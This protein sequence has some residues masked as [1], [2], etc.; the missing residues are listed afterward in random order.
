MIDIGLSGSLLRGVKK[1]TLLG[2]LTDGG[3]F[4]QLGVPLWIVAADLVLQREF[5]FDRGDLG[6]ALDATSAIPTVF[7][8]VSFEDRQLVDGWVV[9]P[10]PADVLRSRG[11]RRGGTTGDPVRP[12]ART[13]CGMTPGRQ[14]PPGPA[15]IPTRPQPGYLP[16][17]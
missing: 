9:N 15:H 13:R 16:V 5:V 12:P 7:P 2:N 1:R 17:M 11:R 3:R 10:L 14:P 8:V 6:V 4:E